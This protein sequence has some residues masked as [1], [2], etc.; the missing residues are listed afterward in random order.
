MNNFYYWYVL[1]PLN[2]KVPT[3]FSKI[4]PNFC[5]HQAIS[6]NFKKNQA[7]FAPQAR[8]KRVGGGGG[9]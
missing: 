8:R 3:L 5:R 2:F 1:V 9:L 6:I 4:M 7:N